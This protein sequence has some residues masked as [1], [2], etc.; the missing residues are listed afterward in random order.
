MQ[1]II[2]NI[3][4]VATELEKKGLSKTASILDSIAEQS[5]QIKTAQYLGVQGYAIRNDRCL[6]NCQRIKKAKNIN[7]SAQQAV[8]ECLNEYSKSINNDNAQWDKYASSQSN[9]KLASQI[10]LKETN[11]KQISELSQ[12][13]NKLELKAIQ[14]S[15]VANKLQ[16]KG[17]QKQAS[18]LIIES[19]NLLKQAQ[20]MNNIKG[21]WNQGKNLVKQPTGTFSPNRINNNDLIGFVKQLNNTLQGY[22][23][24]KQQ[25]QKVLIPLKQS[26]HDVAGKM[27]QLMKNINKN[28]INQMA[29]LLK[30]Q[31]LHGQKDTN[32]QNA[33]TVNQGNA[34]LNLQNKTQTGSGASFNPSNLGKSNQF[35][36]SG[37]IEGQFL[38]NSKQPRVQSYYGQK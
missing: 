4:E 19:D 21:I 12:I 16:Q 36:G 35:G 17:F 24:Q 5:I 20:F 38:G 29:A 14:L 11:F 18:K 31:P 22:L 9:V 13:S 10:P 15:K 7:M 6:K 30:M 2:K 3:T 1:N 25:L 33:P 34:P 27:L 37:N 8:Q 28:S 26:G 23:K 32:T